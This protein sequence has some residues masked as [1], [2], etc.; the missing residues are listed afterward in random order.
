VI[1]CANEGGKVHIQLKTWI[2]QDIVECRNLE[3]YVHIA[4]TFF[5]YN[6]SILETGSVSKTWFEETRDNG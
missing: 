2:I 6:N 3:M 4:S 5:N 1:I